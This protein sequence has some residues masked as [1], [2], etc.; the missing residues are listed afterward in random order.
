MNFNLKSPCNDCPFRTDHPISLRPGRMK[1][2]LN[3][4]LRGDKTFACHKT[5]HGSARETSHCAGAL[6]LLENS[7]RPNFLPRASHALGIYDP[8]KLNMDAPVGIEAD[9]VR[10]HKRVDI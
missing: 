2:I 9:I 1:G 7:G 10:A 8:E 5:T 4:V 3:D 6:I